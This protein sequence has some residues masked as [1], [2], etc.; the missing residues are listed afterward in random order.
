MHIDEGHDVSQNDQDQE[1]LVNHMFLDPSPSP[2]CGDRNRDGARSTGRGT[3]TFHNDAGSGSG[4]ESDPRNVRGSVGHGSG[5]GKESDLRPRP[6]RNVPYTVPNSS[7]KGLQI[8]DEVDGNVNGGV[9]VLTTIPFKPDSGGGIPPD[10]DAPM[11]LLVQQALSE[12]AGGGHDGVD[13]EDLG[14]SPDVFGFNLP[15]HRPRVAMHTHS[16]SDINLLHL[17]LSHVHC[18]IS[19]IRCMNCKSQCNLHPYCNMFMSLTPTFMSLVY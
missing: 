2:P 11:L 14:E 16:V 19:C 18:V 7:D 5:S 17:I 10:D 13:S 3:G 15:I 6:N 9:D 12:A 4:K 1:L 8:D